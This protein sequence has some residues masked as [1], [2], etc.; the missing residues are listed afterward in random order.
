MSFVP[1]YRLLAEGSEVLIGFLPNNT[2]A[3]NKNDEVVYGS[4]G[5]PSITYKVE[6]VRFVAEYMII[7]T[8]EAPDSYSVY[9]RTDLIVSVVP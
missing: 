7:G 2:P 1:G 4:A 3:L 5:G 6:K 8:Q 9:G